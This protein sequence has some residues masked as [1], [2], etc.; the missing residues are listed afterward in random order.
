MNG[1]QHELRLDP[2]PDAVESAYPEG[3]RPKS[4]DEAGELGEAVLN[5]DATAVEGPTE[6]RRQQL[7]GSQSIS[8]LPAMA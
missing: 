5:V 8:A 3:E 7:E 1:V 2:W 6:R 4:A